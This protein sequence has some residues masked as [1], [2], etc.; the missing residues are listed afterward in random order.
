MINVNDGAP[1]AYSALLPINAT[2]VGLVY[3]AGG[4][5]T[6]QYAVVQLR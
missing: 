2:H 4:Y 6:L 3:E 5:K 1:A